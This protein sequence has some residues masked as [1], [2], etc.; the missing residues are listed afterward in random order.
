MKM[1]NVQT[2]PGPG[3]YVRLWTEQC[4]WAAPVSDCVLL[5]FGLVGGN[6]QF[7]LVFMFGQGVV[8]I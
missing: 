7:P 4:A 3:S 5:L 2:Q 6:I 8:Q 1:I